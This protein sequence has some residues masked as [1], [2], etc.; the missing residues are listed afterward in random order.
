MAD[1][2]DL[3]AALIT[4]SDMGYAGER[5][6]TSG[7]RL[8]EMLRAQG[9]KIAGRTILP[10]DRRMLEDEMK[11]LCDGGFCDVVF[12][13]GGTGLSPR[14]IMPEATIAVAD[15]MVP[16]IAEAMRAHSMQYTRRAML[17]RGVCAIRKSTLIVNLPGSPKAVKECLD[18]ILSELPHGI[19]ILRGHTEHGARPANDYKTGGADEKN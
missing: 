13:T 19:E 18:A 10:D 9:Y 1:E 4:S 5:E 17:S 6:D 16:G 11:R 8:E 12:T 15:R 14:D 7:D 2:K 3:R